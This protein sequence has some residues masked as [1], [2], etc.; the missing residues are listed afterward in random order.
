MTNATDRQYINLL[1]FAVVAGIVSVIIMVVT[2]TA[3]A[4]DGVRRLTPAIV[5]IEVGLLL[6]IANAIYKAVKHLNR[7]DDTNIDSKLQV[8]TCPDYW[9]LDTQDEDGGRVCTNTFKD[10]LNPRVE[11]IISGTNADTASL[12]QVRLA[13]YDDKTVRE[14]CT[15]AAEEVRAPWTNV[16]AM[17]ESY[18]LPQGAGL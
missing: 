7:A 15:K 5:T 12:R 16:D 6:I 4:T 11:Y 13:E 14:A 8:T 1:V 18:N 10:P 3:G 9:T 17:C 2:V